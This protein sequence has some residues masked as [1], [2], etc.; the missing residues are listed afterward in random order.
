V[1]WER[2]SHRICAIRNSGLFSFVW[3]GRLGRV[4]LHQVTWTKKLNNKLKVG[5]SPL[6]KMKPESESFTIP[7]YGDS[8]N[9]A[10]GCV[11]TAVTAAVVTENVRVNRRWKAESVAYGICKQLSSS[12]VHLRPLKPDRSPV[13]TV[14]PESFQH[15]VLTSK[16]H[17]Y[18]TVQRNR[19]HE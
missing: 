4:A 14:C 9:S 19:P 3:W 12:F 5:I 15:L 2:F 8:L 16:F 6:S 7:F 10:R 1:C 11:K 17:N 13:C 18:R